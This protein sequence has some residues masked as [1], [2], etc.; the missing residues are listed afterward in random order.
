MKWCSTHGYACD[1]KHCHCGA[2]VG[3]DARTGAGPHLFPF[4]YQPTT[5]WPG[6]PPVLNIIPGFSDYDLGYDYGHA[7]CSSG[8]AL[9]MR[10]TNPS[11]DWLTGYDEGCASV[12][13]ERHHWHTA[14]HVGAT[15]QPCES[16]LER[17]VW[18]AAAWLGGFVLGKMWK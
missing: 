16:L 12:R 5:T 11:D 15:G 4:G 10:P 18:I 6:P 1:G 2:G 9:M 3:A 8:A 13:K 14:G 7:S 17:T